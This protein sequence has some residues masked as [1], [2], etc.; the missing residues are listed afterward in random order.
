M[1][2]EVKVLCHRLVCVLLVWTLYLHSFVLSRGNCKDG[3]WKPLYV[4]ISEAGESHL[5]NVDSR[6]AL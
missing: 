2:R 1:S 4:K 6:T 3:E 5:F